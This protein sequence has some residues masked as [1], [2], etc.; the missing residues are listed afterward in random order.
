MFQIRSLAWICTLGKILLGF[1]TSPQSIEVTGSRR[2][3]VGL[4]FEF[5]CFPHTG[6]SWIQ[7][8]CDLDQLRAS[9]E[10]I[11]SWVNHW[12]HELRFAKFC[13]VF[14]WKILL[15]CLET[16]WLL[17]FHPIWLIFLNKIHFDVRLDLES[18]VLFI[19]DKMIHQTFLPHSCIHTWAA[20]GDLGY[21][22]LHEW[23]SKHHH[24]AYRLKFLFLGCYLL[25]HGTRFYFHN[26]NSW[27]I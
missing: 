2:F 17:R 5:F 8:S 13:R 3:F 16:F 11:R 19:E 6:T 27:M 18:F 21:L 14:Y 23:I 20:W 10:V 25:I 7:S 9:S 12:I 4:A 24:F 22:V 1:V 26:G 15:Q